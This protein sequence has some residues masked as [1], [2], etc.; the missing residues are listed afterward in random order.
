[1]I[2]KFLDW[3]MYLKGKLTDVERDIF[4]L[5]VHFP[6]SCN[7]HSQSRRKPRAENSELVFYLGGRPKHVDHLPLPSQVHWQEAS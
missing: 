2:V 3:F 1:M 7:S 6:N 5:L 4:S